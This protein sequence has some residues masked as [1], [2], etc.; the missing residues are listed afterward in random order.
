MYYHRAWADIDVDALTRNLFRI[1][2]ALSPGTGVMAVV[3]ADAYGHGAI[4][5]ARVLQD[6]AGLWGFGVGDSREALELRDAGIASPILILGAIIEDE[7]G[8]VLENEIAVCVHSTRRI[9]RLDRA[10]QRQDKRLKVPL[11]VDTGMG[12]LGVTPEKAID[13]ARGIAAAPGLDI[14]GV[15]TH[16]SCTS[17]P[18]DPF[19][20]IQLRRFL[21]L[22]ESLERAGI[23]PAISHASNSSS[24]F[25]SLSQHFDLVRPGISLFGIAPDGITSSGLD[26]DPVLSL[27]TQVVFMKDIPAGT[28]VGYNRT[29]TTERATRIAT[30][31]IGYNDGYPFR[32]SNRGRVLIRG[33]RAP[34]VG[35]VTMDYTMVDIGHI[36]GVEVGDMVTLIGRDGDESISVGEIARM[37]GTIPY[38]I[39]CLI[40]K[41]VQRIARKTQS[42]TPPSDSGARDEKIRA[43]IG[44]AIHR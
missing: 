17:D 23:A 25:S 26:L 14:A 6:Q 21:T 22:R 11:M 30:I 28:P 32:L 31:P 12:R 13:V 27:R 36:P 8:R 33:R 5:I 1:R 10:A 15:A 38:E 24:I 19:T 29:Y 37:V 34:V 7:I 44:Q 3:K 4:T 2:A 9:E 35:G 41:R 18:E 43:P 16:Y 20:A 39:I 42:E 40:G